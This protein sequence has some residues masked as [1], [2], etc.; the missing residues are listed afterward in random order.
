MNG[1]RPA[2]FLG[3]ECAW[4]DPAHRLSRR[5]ARQTPPLGRAR[6]LRWAFPLTMAVLLGVAAWQLGAA[7][8]I[9]AKAW[10]AQR[11][12]QDAWTQS[13]ATGQPTRPWPWADTWPVARL[14]LPGRGV[15]VY[16]LAGA[17]GRTLAFGPGH[18]DGSAAP[19]APGNTVLA[20]HR[21]T[22]FAFLRDL[23]AG[24]MMEL[25][26]I[27]G[28]ST[29]YR[30]RGVGVVD[31]ADVG[32]LAQPGAGRHLTLVTCYPF[33]ALRAGGPLRYVVMAEG[34]GN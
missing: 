34:V 31:K 21:D 15:D 17:S 28:R 22:H 2:D 12:I 32:V 33:D 30:V 11:L 19:G 10:L 1:T 26:D 3:L 5:D 29:R 13:L 24:A 25:Q 20:G 16:V 14:T 7:G 23:P 9:Q 27:H 18:L 4:P 6:G 8:Y